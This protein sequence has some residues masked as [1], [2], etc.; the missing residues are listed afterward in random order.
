MA[1]SRTGSLLPFCRAKPKTSQ[2]NKNG[3]DRL[4]RILQGIKGV[5]LQSELENLP[6]GNHAFVALALAAHSG[7]RLQA[8]SA[9]T[10]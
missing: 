10:T 5:Q 7:W 4:R 9:R 1:K 8:P 3:N 6:E 2:A